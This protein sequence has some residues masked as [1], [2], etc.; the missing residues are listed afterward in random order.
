MSIVPDRLYVDTSAGLAKLCRRLSGCKWLAIDTEFLREKT[1]FPKLCLLQVANRELVAWVDVLVLTDLSPLLGILYDPGVTKVLHSGFQDLEILYNLCGKLPIP[2]FDT[3][4]AAH[5]LGDSDQIGYAPLVDKVLGVKLNKAH[6]RSD[7]TYRP[8]SPEQLQYAEDDVVYLA[9]LYPLLRKRLEE[10]NRLTWLDEECAALTKLERYD[11]PPSQ[12]W[13]R[14]RASKRLKGA[15]LSVFQLLAAWREETSRK[16]D[17]PR[18][19]LIH[20]DTIMEIAR[21]TPENPENLACIQGISRR[22]LKRYGEAL[23]SL[24]RRGRKM[25]PQP[26]KLVHL[27]PR[28]QAQVKSLQKVVRKRAQ[29]HSLNPMLMASRKDLESLVTGSE[30]T[31]LLKGWRRE[32]IGEELL[33]LLAR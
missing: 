31:P 26:I 18:N 28:Q 19:W 11:I 9:L 8:L 7:W 29:E 30:E 21:N 3:Q 16:E 23:L 1:Y 15:N 13:I 4:I 6:T 5:L 27:N 10:R 20:N 33:A 22:M 17:R 2:V 14:I 24:V 25:A 12:A 32:L